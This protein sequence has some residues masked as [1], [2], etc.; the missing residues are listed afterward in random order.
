MEYQISSSVTE[1][2][3]QAGEA[4]DRPLFGS[5]ILVPEG[6]GSGVASS[7]SRFPEPVLKV[8]PGGRGQI[9]FRGMG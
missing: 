5:Q 6:T 2:I 7:R 8:L 3:S 4:I 1:G 9:G